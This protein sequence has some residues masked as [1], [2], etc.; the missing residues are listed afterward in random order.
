MMSSSSCFIREAS[1]Q[2]TCCQGSGL[3]FALLKQKLFKQLLGLKAMY[4]HE[5]VVGVELDL[6]QA[7]NSVV[8][9]ETLQHAGGKLQGTP[10]GGRHYHG[11]GAALIIIEIALGTDGRREAG[12]AAG[13]DID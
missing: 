13:R 11:L 5:L 3:S 6:E 2:S 9:H 12:A 8:R 7:M 10:I 4:R 1:T